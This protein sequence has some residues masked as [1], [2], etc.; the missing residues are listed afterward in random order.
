[1]VKKL[2][3]LILGALILSGFSSGVSTVNAGM[4][5]TRSIYKALFIY[6]FATL[7]DWPSEYRKGDF[8]IGV[9]GNG[10]SV[11][12]ELLKKYNGKAIGAQKITVKKYNSISEIKTVPHILYL[13]EEKSDKITSVS[14][15]YSRKSSLLITEKEGY[16]NKGSIIN[17]VIDRKKNNK[18]SYEI[19]KIN[20]KKHKLV[21]A[22]K[23][24]SLA[25][26]VVE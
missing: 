23:L 17:F 22:S 14:S 12:S 2:Y 26:K 7:V 9:Y 8:I 13:T 5:D 15:K 6:N 10:N 18:Q 3:I 4:R 19:S 24:T 16:L 25:V 1:M 11:H 21:I 20:A